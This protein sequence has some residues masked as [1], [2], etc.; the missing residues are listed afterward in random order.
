[1]NLIEITDMCGILLE[2]IGH[3]KIPLRLLMFQ[4]NAVQAKIAS[5]IADQECDLFIASATQTPSSDGVTLPVDFL[6]ARDISSDGY[7][8]EL[9]LPG[10]RHYY[11]STLRNWLGNNA[12]MFYAYLRGNKVY[13]NSN[14]TNDVTFAYTRRLP[15]LHRGTSRL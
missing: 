10:Q 5:D 2:D 6:R 14:M 12:G 13:Y 7:P 9:I 15:K 11:G 8:I 3:T 1:M 4:I